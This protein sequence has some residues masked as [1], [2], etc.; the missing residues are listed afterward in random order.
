MLENNHTIS[1]LTKIESG[2]QKTHFFEIAAESAN[3][4]NTRI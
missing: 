3:S 1:A 2:A 4:K